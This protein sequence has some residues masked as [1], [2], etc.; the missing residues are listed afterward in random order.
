MTTDEFIARYNPLSF[1]HFTDSRNIPLIAEHGLCAL[2]EIRRKG[3]IIPAPGGNE[4]SHKLDWEKGLASYVHL[5]F[6]GEH[7]ME[8]VARAIEKRLDQTAFLAVSRNVLHLDGIRFTAEV[9]NRS[10]SSLLTL[11]QAVERMDFP[12][13]FD[14]TDW[15]DPDI[16]RRRQV[17]KKYEI[18]VPISIPSE[19]LTFPNHG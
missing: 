12:V 3:I 9:A 8:Y 6:H 10:G 14:R 19:F 17:T 2:S 7:P 5:C 16:N 15:S 1:F 4:L 13:I 18:L 11:D